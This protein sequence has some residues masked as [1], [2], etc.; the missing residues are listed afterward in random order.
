M[1]IAFAVFLVLHGVAHLVGFLTP[2][3]L[4][5][6]RAPGQP[7]PP[8]PDVLFDGRLLVGDLAAR[9]LGIAWLALALAFGAVAVGLLRNERWWPAALVC[10]VLG[11]MAMSVAFWPA[12][13]I[14]VWIDAALLLLAA[15]LLATGRMVAA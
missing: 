7:P 2:F 15:A 1:R 10:T 5:P 8:R 12:A 14:G 9:T 11:S 4:G 3:G 6:A 13:R